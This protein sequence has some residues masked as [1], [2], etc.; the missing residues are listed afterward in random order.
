MACSLKPLDSLICKSMIRTQFAAS[1]LLLALNQ[2]SRLLPLNV[3]LNWLRFIKTVRYYF[4]NILHGKGALTSFYS[5]LE[6]RS[7]SKDRSWVF[8]SS[9][10]C[11]SLACSTLG[12][13]RWSPRGETAKR[14]TAPDC[15]C[16]VDLPCGAASP[17]IRFASSLSASGKWRACSGPELW[18]LRPTRR[19]HPLRRDAL[20]PHRMCRTPHPCTSSS[21]RIL[22]YDF[23]ALQQRTA[24]CFPLYRAVKNR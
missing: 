10:S 7:S 21:C 22:D 13:P 1:S 4:R 8:P 18:I 24:L 3:I 11:P 12:C 6:W 9:A 23:L 17:L 16:R 14:G 5:S 20:H 19:R 2:N 15:T